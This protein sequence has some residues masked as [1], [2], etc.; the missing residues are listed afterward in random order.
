MMVSRAVLL[1]VLLTV[2]F[3]PALMAS[4]IFVGTDNAGN[5]LPFDQSAPLDITEYQQV[6]AGSQFPGVFTFSSINFLEAG[7][8]GYMD[9]AT[10]QISFSTTAAAPGAL[11]TNLGSNIGSNVQAFGT[12][13]LSNGVAPSEITFTGTPYTY[14]PSNGNLLMDVI[15]SD[16]VADLHGFYAG[17][18]ADS[19][20][21]VT[22][23][24]YL[25]SGVGAADDVGLVTEFDTPEPGT[26][27]FA[28]AGLSLLLLRYRA[29]KG[30]A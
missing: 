22:S 10:F 26:V 30:R 25:E 14:N 19:T 23:R 5:S 15:I 28:A 2:A 7:T 29:L 11:S 1:F 6:Y 9:T 17:E 13:T 27:G 16:Q 24:A 4:A 8:S 12:F 20:G 18:E 21:T 3:R